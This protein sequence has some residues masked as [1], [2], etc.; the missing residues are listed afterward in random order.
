[1]SN[2]AYYDLISDSAIPYFGGNNF[3]LVSFLLFVN[4]HFIEFKIFLM[5]WQMADTCHVQ[6]NCLQET[7]IYIPCSFIHSNV[8]SVSL[9]VAPLHPRADTGPYILRLHSVKDCPKLIESSLVFFL[10]YLSVVYRLNACNIECIFAVTDICIWWLE[11][12]S[13]QIPLEHSASFDGLVW[14][15]STLSNA[16][17]QHYIWITFHIFWC[18]AAKIGLR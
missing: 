13:G 18:Y 14:H 8:P 10:I 3:S 11:L 7:C 5:A 15:N 6:W 17:E 9:I 12:I 1:M 2:F 4:I 16:A